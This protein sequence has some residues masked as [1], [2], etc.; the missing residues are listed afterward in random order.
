MF[1]RQFNSL[2]QT[3]ITSFFNIQVDVHLHLAKFPTIF[4]SY[5]WLAQSKDGGTWQMYRNYSFYNQ[6]LEDSANIGNF[7]KM[8]KYLIAPLQICFFE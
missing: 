6:N 3:L 1:Y 7:P 5:L 4:Y 2:L 8:Q